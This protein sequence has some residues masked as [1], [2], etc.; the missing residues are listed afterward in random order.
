MIYS[1]NSNYP[2]EYDARF[3][4]TFL[5]ALKNN[6]DETLY[7]VFYKKI[8]EISNNRFDIDRDSPGEIKKANRQKDFDL[9]FDKNSFLNEIKKYLSL[10]NAI[11]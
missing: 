3:I 2:D 6:Q 11:C 1:E 5:N 7:E 9:F 10:K 8:N 4:E